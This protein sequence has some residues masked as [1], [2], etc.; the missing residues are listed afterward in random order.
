[1]IESFSEDK[2]QVII[3]ILSTELRTVLSPKALALICQTV[4]SPWADSKLSDLRISPRLVSL[5][6]QG[7]N[8]ALLGLYRLCLRC[9][10]ERASQPLSTDL[11]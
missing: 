5:I 3:M 2:K 11:C 1:M 4:S 10:R 9:I 6:Q 7:Q 8:I